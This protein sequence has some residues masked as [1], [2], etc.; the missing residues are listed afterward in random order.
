MGGGDISRPG[1][2]LDSAATFGI[3]S[4]ERHLVRYGGVHVELC[5]RESFT[6]NAYEFVLGMCMVGRLPGWRRRTSGHRH[7]PTVAPRAQ[8]PVEHGQHQMGPRRRSRFAWNDTTERGPD[9]YG[10]SSAGRPRK[11]RLPIVPRE[12]SI[13]C[14]PVP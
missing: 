4:P 1:P 5:P 8:F 11:P 7:F 2:I 6:W 13:S 3:F 9:S 12:T 10:R 14:A